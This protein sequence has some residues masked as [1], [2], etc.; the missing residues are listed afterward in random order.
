MEWPCAQLVRK[1]AAAS[2]P[3]F[4]I[5]NFAYY[6]IYILVFSVYIKLRAAGRHGEGRRMWDFFL[7]SDSSNNFIYST[8]VQHLDGTIPIYINILLTAPLKL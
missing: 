6:H 8:T 7:N 3:L 5:N 2:S 4:F 1:C